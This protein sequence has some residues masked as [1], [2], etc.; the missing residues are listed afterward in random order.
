MKAQDQ[1]SAIQALDELYYGSTDA[2]RKAAGAAAVYLI[3]NNKNPTLEAF[4]TDLQDPNYL[5]G[6]PNLG[7][8]GA[9]NLF[10][11]FKTTPKEPS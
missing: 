5:N 1:E 10:A 3:N 4:L 9:A 6:I 11:Y 8:Q 2:L 7:K